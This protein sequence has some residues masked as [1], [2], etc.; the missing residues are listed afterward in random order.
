[1]KHYVYRITDLSVNRHYIGIRSTKLDPYDDLGKVYF[2]SSKDRAFIEKQ[3]E[4]PSCFRYKILMQFNSR[5]LAV[6]FEIKIHARLDVGRNPAFFN[7]SRQTN[8]GFSTLGMVSV[9]G[10]L[11]TVDEYRA[12]GLK[13]HRKGWVIATDVS[14]EIFHARQDDNRFEDGTIWS[15]TKDRVRAIRSD[16]SKVIV[17]RS[18]YYS[19]E[20]TCNNTGKVPAILPDGQKS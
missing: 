10:R 18:E 7:R 3:R 12:S 19:G 16:G 11:M 17:S 2:S 9:N 5:D 4:H 20:Y 8:T 6:A 13:H 14:G 1:M 15:A